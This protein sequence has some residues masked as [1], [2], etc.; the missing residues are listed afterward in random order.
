MLK[1]LFGMVRSQTLRAR[2]YWNYLRVIFSKFQG[3]HVP[4]I[5]LFRK[6][7]KCSVFYS[8]KMSHC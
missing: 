4:S 7:V 6:M 1:T 8:T 2:D 5:T 3:H